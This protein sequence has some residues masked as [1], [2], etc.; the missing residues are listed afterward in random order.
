MD[1]QSRQH[2]NGGGDGIGRAGAGPGSIFSVLNKNRETQK[3]YLSPALVSKSVCARPRDDEGSCPLTTEWVRAG[4]EEEAG[5]EGPEL[6]V[7]P[8]LVRPTEGLQ[9]AYDPRIPQAHQKFR[10]EIRGL[11]E[12]ARVEWGLDDA[13]ILGGTEATLL[14]PVT[15]GAHILRVSLFTP[16]GDVRSLDPVRFTVK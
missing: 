1:G 9:I 13:P 5:H 12:G 3:L 8:E 14:W 6:S 16:D 2:T 11:P 15:K 7:M 4:Y 10:F